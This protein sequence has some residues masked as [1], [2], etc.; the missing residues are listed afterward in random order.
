MRSRLTQ[1]ASG[2]R[3]APLGRTK[4]VEE[5]KP[6]PV[7]SASTQLH[8]RCVSLLLRFPLSHPVGGIMINSPCTVRSSRKSELF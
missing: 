3:I 1:E 4:A 6:N 5:S 8:K 7:L 2:E